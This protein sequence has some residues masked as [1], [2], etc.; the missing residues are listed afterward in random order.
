MVVETIVLVVIYQKDV[1]KNVEN[2]KADMYGDKELFRYDNK[3]QITTVYL[4]CF[5]SKIHNSID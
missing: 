3:Y 2:S 5:Y 1:E 4:Q